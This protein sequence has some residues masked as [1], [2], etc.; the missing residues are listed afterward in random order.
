MSTVVAKGVEP[1]VST[2]IRPG[3]RRRH[4]RKRVMAWVFS[5]PALLAFTLFGW[6]PMVMAFLVAFQHYKI[7]GAPQWIG[8]ANFARVFHDPVVLTALLNSAY[9]ALLTI[10]LTFWVPIIVSVLLMEMPERLR[11]LMMILWFIPVPAVASIVIWKYFYDPNYGLFNAMFHVFGIHGFLWL[12][13]PRWAMFLIVLPGLI[14]YGP[15]LIFISTLQAVPQE[16]YEAAELDGAS[17]LRKVW[18]ITIPTLRPIIMVLLLLS[19]IGNLQV[20]TQPYIMTAGG[21]VFATLTGVLYIFNNAFRYLRFG[22]ADALAIMLFLIL[23]VLVV[24]QRW[25]EARNR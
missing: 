15:G 17:F 1:A 2:G 11:N 13:S 24:V 23:A 9:Y 25:L 14:M 16:L 10:G 20:F 5:V 18:A 6:Y 22:Y 8:W 21:P 3:P 19:I 12:D 7:V 4:G